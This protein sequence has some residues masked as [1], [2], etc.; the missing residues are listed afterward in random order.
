M[1]DVTVVALEELSSGLVMEGFMSE[2]TI[3]VVDD[4]PSISEV[5][6]IHLPSEGY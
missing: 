1:T 6:I 5:V 4:E 2:P 3:L